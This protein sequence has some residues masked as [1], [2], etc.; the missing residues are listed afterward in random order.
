VIPLECHLDKL[1]WEGLALAAAPSLLTN[2]TAKVKP[3]TT[4]PWLW[5]GVVIRIAFISHLSRESSFH[6]RMMIVRTAVT[7]KMSSLK[8]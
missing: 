3:K 1:C 7:R 2:L 8:W 6:L 4:S 5:F